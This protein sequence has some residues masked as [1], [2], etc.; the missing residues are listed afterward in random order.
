MY[1]DTTHVQYIVLFFSRRCGIIINF[2]QRVRLSSNGDAVMQ[3]IKTLI[4]NILTL[5]LILQHGHYYI[6]SQSLTGIKTHVSNQSA[7]TM[8]QFNTS[9]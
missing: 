7:V 3:Y 9:L 2:Y 4:Q 1:I 8:K 5:S 6:K